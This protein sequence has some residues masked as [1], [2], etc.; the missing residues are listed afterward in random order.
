MKL[1]WLQK[2]LGV[3]IEAWFYK[4][5][6]KTEDILLLHK[7]LLLLF[8]LILIEQIERCHSIIVIENFI[9]VVIK[10]AVSKFTPLKLLGPQWNFTALRL[11]E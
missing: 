9:V 5:I 2:I 4:K 10:I 3:L 11:L 6:D 7:K 1:K 8:L